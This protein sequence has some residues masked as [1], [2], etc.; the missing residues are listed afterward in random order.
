MY[1]GNQNG[2]RFFQSCQV[3]SRQPGRIHNVGWL[4]LANRIIRL[5]ISQQQPASELVRL[6]NFIVNSYDPIFFR[7][8]CNPHLEQG[9]HNFFFLLRF[10]Q[11]LTENDRLIVNRSY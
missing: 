4:T 6:V 8:K 5:H 2:V 7:I 3:H 10:V 9:A 1:L 11:E